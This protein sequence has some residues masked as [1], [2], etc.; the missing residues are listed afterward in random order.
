MNKQRRR[1]DHLYGAVFADVDERSR[2]A[3]VLLYLSVRARMPWHVLAWHDLRRV[4]IGPRYR[5]G[6]HATERDA[7]RDYLDRLG[8]DPAHRRPSCRLVRS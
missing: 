1:L 5:T 6:D 8:L 3:R 4:L 7:W 2:D